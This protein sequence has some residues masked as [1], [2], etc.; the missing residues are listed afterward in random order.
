MYICTCIYNLPCLKV[1]RR[2][3][4]STNLGVSTITLHNDLCTFV[5]RSRWRS[6]I[7]TCHI[8]FIAGK[9]KQYLG[10]WRNYRSPAQAPGSEDGKKE[11]NESEHKEKVWVYIHVHLLCPFTLRKCLIC[12]KAY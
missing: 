4:C 3:N 10:A 1:V 5:I 7:H 9:Q 12:G 8:L 2:F 11:E 6:S